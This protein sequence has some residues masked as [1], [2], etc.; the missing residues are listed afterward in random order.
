MVL[1]KKTD[2]TFNVLPQGIVVL[3]SQNRS[4][5]PNDQSGDSYNIILSLTRSS[6]T[7]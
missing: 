7:S 6:F 3:A 2:L 5:Y 4:Q 1:R